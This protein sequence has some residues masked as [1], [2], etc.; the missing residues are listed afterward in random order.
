MNSHLQAAPDWW[1]SGLDDIERLVHTVKKG[2]V[3]Q[4]GK[5]AGNRNMYLFEYGKRD[6]YERTA[7]YSSALGCGYISTYKQN[8]HPH[9]LI[10]NGV[11]GGEWE[12][13]V[14]SLNLIHIF[15]TGKDFKGVAYPELAAMPKQAYFAIIPSANPDGRARIT[16]NTVVGM[17]RISFRRLDQ[18]EWKNG[19]YCEW[20]DVK[21]IH[22]IKDHVNILGAYFNDDGVNL[23]HDSFTN[24]MAE[25]TRVLMQTVDEVA[26][27]VILDMH[28][29]GGTGKGHLI[30]S[31]HQS[32][33]NYQKCLKLDVMLGERLAERGYAWNRVKPIEDRLAVPRFNLDDAMNLT[34]GAI[35][36]TYESDQGIIYK[37]GDEQKLKDRHE[38]IYEKHLVLYATVFDFCRENL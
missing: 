10:I 32:T 11:H 27:D 23:M 18:G 37:Q 12:G 13:I 29:H 25:E 38:R 36:M 6:V 33:E 26:P 31:Y 2:N 5:S 8:K 1:K 3:R 4:I 17:D 24:P 7:N 21:K 28:G 34:C 19:E 16:Q 9:I 14:S 30:P 22:P 35:T 20:P 15:E